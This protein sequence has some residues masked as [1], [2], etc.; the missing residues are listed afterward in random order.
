MR[1][2]EKLAAKARDNLH[3][4]GVTIAF[5]GDSVTQGC[6]EVFEKN[7][8]GIEAVYDPRNAYH[9]QLQDI[10]AVLYPTVTVSIINAGI[11]GD[12]ATA[13]VSR[14]ERDVLHRNPD[15][16]V[17]CFGLNDSGGGDP[18]IPRYTDSLRTIF[19]RLKE[20]GSEVVF[21]TPNLKATEISCHVPQGMQRDI[22]KTIADSQL[23]GTMDRYM[24]AARALC[25]EEQVPVCDCYK[26][27]QT[28]KHGG[29]NTTE[30]LSNYLNHPTREMNWMFAYSL[31]ETFFTA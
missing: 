4:P 1:I 28:L 30:L 23:D 13:A 8:G 29:V 2:I 5:L 31:V 24:D 15:L 7:D 6:F 22:A 21:L 9:R 19:R 20:N 11:G 26:K 25:A 14:L 17:V 3:E 18:G 27:W 16:T 10:L 12:N